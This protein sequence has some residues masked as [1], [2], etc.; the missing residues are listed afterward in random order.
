M[1]GCLLLAFAL[2]EDIPRLVEKLRSEKVEEREEAFQKL[3]EIGEAALLRPR[4]PPVRFP[5]DARACA[6]SRF[7]S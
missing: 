1:L 4:K 3:R 6:S 7:R 2:Q 5:C